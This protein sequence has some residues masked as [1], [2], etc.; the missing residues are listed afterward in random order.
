MP[1]KVEVKEVK[2]KESKAKSK[3]VAKSEEEEIDV[4]D[5]LEEV[6]DDES[7]DD[8]TTK[9]KKNVKDKVYEEKERDWELVELPKNVLDDI[10]IIAEERKLNEKQTSELVDA[11]RTRYESILVEP[12]EACGII[13][14]QSLGEPA[15]QLTLR[16]KHFAGAAEVSVG[17]GI[18]R[19]EE[20]VDGR[21]KAK[22]PTMTI[23]LNDEL[24]KNKE[25]VEKYAQT[26]V[27]VRIV[28]LVDLK[29]NFSENEF[30]ITL[31][32]KELELRG[33]NV[34]EFCDTI[35]KPLKDFP[36][37][38]K[39]P[40]LYFQIPKKGDL[41]KV[42]KA[43]VKLLR[44]RAQGIV[45]IQKVIVLKEND[46]YVIK[47]SGSNLKAVLKLEEIKGEKIYTN[48]IAEV[49][50][51]LGVEAGR[52]MVVNE[53]HN[54]L[55]ENGISVDVRHIMLLADMMTFTGD[56]KG[57]VRTGITREKA[58]PLARAAFEETTKHLLEA[59][60]KGEK[61]RLNGVVENIIVGQ[62]IKVGTGVVELLYKIKK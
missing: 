41:L 43:L 5:A 11:I 30:N 28:D 37:K 34:E 24:R 20:I 47:T 12:G 57:I 35:S 39:K 56:I 33:I 2:V 49:C 10:V 44:T 42:R 18:Q 7:D 1:K 55:K 22:Y 60:F 13:A 25:A 50:K 9:S 51:V 46:E 38:Y 16:T 6:E 3:K 58:S 59:A 27:D 52:A 36:V 26:L 61:E 45:G 48:D 29:E 53:M 17:S 54:V 31:K 32:E 23:Y 14:A 62:P 40:T 21:S 15:T 4:L 8:K 19:V